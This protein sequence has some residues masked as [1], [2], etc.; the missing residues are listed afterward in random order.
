MYKDVTIMIN[1]MAAGLFGLT[2]ALFLFVFRRTHLRT[3]LGA[4]LAIY[5]LYLTKDVIYA[6]DVI[7]NDDYLYRM[8]LSID[9]WVVP[10]YVI[11]AVEVLEAR[12]D[13]TVASRMP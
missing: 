5:T 4:I 10:L 7:A 8:L 12:K 9:N 3:V 1:G 11:Y 13:D 6:Y 2:S